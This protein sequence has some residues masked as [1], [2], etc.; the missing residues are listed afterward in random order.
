MRSLLMSPLSTYAARPSPLKCANSAF[1]SECL[2][3]TDKRPRQQVRIVFI[4]CS[5]PAPADWLKTFLS[6][7]LLLGMLLLLWMLVL[8]PAA[9]REGPTIQAYKKTKQSWWVDYDLEDCSHYPTSPP[10]SSSSSFILQIVRGSGNKASEG[11]TAG[12]RRSKARIL[13]Y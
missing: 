6:L 2:T 11:V 13:S 4:P 10:T 1:G 12:S 5:R 3:K 9:C 8:L 7:L